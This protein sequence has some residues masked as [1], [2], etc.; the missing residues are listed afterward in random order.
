MRRPEIH[1][2]G[3]ELLAREVGEAALVSPRGTCLVRH[4][5]N[6]G[7]SREN[8]GGIRTLLGT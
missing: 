1:P 7:S 5:D 2:D 4:I 3:D 8:D 6:K